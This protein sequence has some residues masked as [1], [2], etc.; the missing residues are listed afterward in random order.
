MGAASTILLLLG[1]AAPPP[2]AVPLTWDAP[3]GCPDAAGVQE[4]LS[5]AL[6][7]APEDSRTDLTAAA[8][9]TTGS[10]GAFALDLRLAGPGMSAVRTLESSDCR[11]LADAAVLIVALAADPTVLDRGAITPAPTTPSTDPDPNPDPT[12]EPN[13]NPEPEPE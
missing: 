3:A 4:R 7:D 9:V 12:P 13:P 1:V 5:A 8:T 6:A 10:D 2:D 11:E